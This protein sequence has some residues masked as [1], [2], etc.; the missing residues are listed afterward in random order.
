MNKTAKGLVEYCKAQLGR[1]YW[2]GTYGQAASKPLYNYLKG[3]YPSKYTWDYAGEVAKVH[4]C[5]GLV[6]GYLWCD[7]P[8]DLTPFYCEAQDISANMMRDVSACDEIGTIPDVPGVLVFYNGHCGVYIGSGEVI[9]A[10]GHKYG[11]VKTKLKD[12]PWKWWGYCPFISYEEPEQ[13]DLVEIVTVELPVLQKGDKSDCVKA[14]QILLMGYGCN[15]GGYGADSSFGGA[16]ERALK[17]YQ[18]AYGLEP[19]GSC[20]PK[21]WS[22]LLGL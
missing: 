9:E 7:S 3:A 8:E 15:L 17:A 13:E 6:K 20:G 21:T 22:K 4:D 18:A 14:M 12:R 19:D 2:Y 10:R 11:V 1:P 16:T 5:C